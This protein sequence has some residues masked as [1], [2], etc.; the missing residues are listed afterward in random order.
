[1]GSRAVLDALV[2]QLGDVGLPVTW[3]PLAA[4]PPC[5]LV[6]VPDGSEQ[7]TACVWKATVPVWVIAPR[8][9]DRFDVGRL[10]DVLDLVV[11]RLGAVQW[12]WQ[13]YVT[14]TPDV[15]LPAV[16]VTVSGTIS[17]ERTTP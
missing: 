11:T 1:M 15:T 17:I 8:S 10:L 9:W 4:V 16:R 13:P 5:V 14:T 2:A 12:G 3:D 7:A 6:G